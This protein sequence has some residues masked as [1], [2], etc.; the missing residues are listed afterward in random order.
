MGIDQS[1]QPPKVRRDFVPKDDYVSRE[2]A[3]AERARLW[4]KV[5]QVACR[6]EELVRVGDFVTYDIC[7]QSVIVT[8]SAPDKIQA[9]YNVCLHRGRRLTAGCGHATRFHCNYHGWR[10][11]LDGSVQRVLDHSDWDGCPSVSPDDLRLRELK[12]GFWGGFVFINFDPA[13]EPLEAYLDPVPDYCDG[14]EL[15]R[16]RYRWSYSV[17]VPCNWKVSLEAFDEGYHVAATHPQLLEF[18]GEDRTYSKAMGKHGMFGYERSESHPYGGPSPRLAR[19]VPKDLRPG[20]IGYADLIDKTLHAI[21]TERDAA[22]ARRLMTEASA[23]DAPLELVMK[24][25]EFQKEA[26]VA[27]GAGWPNLTPEARA[28]A[29]TDWHV[30]PNLIFLPGPTGTLAYRS[31]P[32]GD[33]SDPDWCVYD[34]WS[35]E[36]YAPG[37]EPARKH[38]QLHGDDDWRQIGDV[39]VILQ[40]DFDNMAEVQ[41]GMKIDGFPGSRTSPVQEA[42]ISNMHRVLHDYVSSSDAG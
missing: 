9:F 12:V 20:I 23:D 7:N 32:W 28:K 35:L 31:R 36:R 25:V 30:F 34:I 29:G 1:N 40:Q 18:M 33:G 21:T 27:A 5:W 13:A 37:A 22:A 41:R 26:A 15:A 11:N 2:F 17:K 42:A 16:M 6:E 14:F 39:S 24:M 19:P 4:P 38:N 10:W 8:R 3:L